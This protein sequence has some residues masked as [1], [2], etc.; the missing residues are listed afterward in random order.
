MGSP[1][2]PH[3]LLFRI[4][5]PSL[6]RCTQSWTLNITKILLELY[7]A[8]E[9]S[10]M[11]FTWRYR[12]MNDY[13]AIVLSSFKAGNDFRHDISVTRTSI[14]GEKT[15]GGSWSMVRFHWESNEASRSW[16]GY[17]MKK[18]EVRET[19]DKKL[20]TSHWS[21]QNTRGKGHQ[22]TQSSLI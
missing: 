21:L 8:L 22:L 12:N 2:T 11:V 6:C 14:F 4:T 5:S 9:W 1:E 17:L 18:L 7:E 10:R 15:I 19:E 13:L 3:L 20:R 16:N